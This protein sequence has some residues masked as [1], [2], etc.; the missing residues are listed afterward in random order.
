LEVTLSQVQEIGDE[1][2]ATTGYRSFSTPRPFFNHEVY[3]VL[4][5]SARRKLNTIWK[6]LKGLEK[7][8]D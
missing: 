2:A 6:N 5:G 3:I 1:L 4:A 7:Q 8:H